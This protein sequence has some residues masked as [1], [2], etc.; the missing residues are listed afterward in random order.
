M[1]DNALISQISR[2]T[3]YLIIIITLC[4]D[5]QS[6]T[7]AYKNL[8]EAEIKFNY[9]RFMVNDLCAYQIEDNSSAV[10][11]LIFISRNSCGKSNKN[12]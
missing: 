6:L 2:H 4:S 9:T 11:E 12:Q 1:H 7:K 3:H 10:C 5:T 8:N